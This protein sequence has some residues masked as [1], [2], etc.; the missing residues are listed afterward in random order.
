VLSLKARPRLIADTANQRT[1]IAPDTPTI[2]VGIIAE[3]AVRMVCAVRLARSFW[4]GSYEHFPPPFGLGLQVG[5]SEEQAPQRVLV[6]IVS[7]RR[8]HVVFHRV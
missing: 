8:G 4:V 2:A 1:V 5:Q 6:M 7:F 3:P